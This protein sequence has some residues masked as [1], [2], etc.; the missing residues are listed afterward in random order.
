MLIGSILMANPDIDIIGLVATIFL[1]I[2]FIPYALQM[3]RG[4]GSV[5]NQSYATVG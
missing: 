5:S 2:G 3:M 1:G 4:A